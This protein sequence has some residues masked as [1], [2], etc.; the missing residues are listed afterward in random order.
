MERTYKL[1]V[2]AC[3]AALLSV[4]AFAQMGP[5]AGMGGMG[6]GM[7]G[8]G[9]GPRALDCSKARDKA[10]CEAH[11]KALQTCGTQ[12]GPAHRECMEDQMPAPDCSKA[13]NPQRCEAQQKTRDACKGKYGPDRR[14]CQRENRPAAARP[15]PRQGGMGGGMGPGAG[16]GMGGGMAPGMGGMPPAK[17]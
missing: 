8:T 11:N 17:K 6:A 4:S 5:G 14:A 16:P 10:Q 7:A 2:G 3:T 15:G 9:A 1:L 13:R 12:R